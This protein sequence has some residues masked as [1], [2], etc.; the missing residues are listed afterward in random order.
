VELLVNPP[1][2]VFEDDH[3]LV[4]NKPPGLNTHAPSPFAGEGLFDWL[5]HR[6]ARWAAL[7]IIHRLDKET[8]GLI[9]FSKTAEANRSLTDQF[10]NRRVKKRYVF[11][12]DRAVADSTFTLK[13]SLVRV[14]DR[15]LSRPVSAAGPVAETRFRMLAK[16]ETHA[17]GQGT[18]LQAEPVTGRTHQIRVHAAEAGIPILGDVRYGGTPAPRVCL[19]AAELSLRHP[20]SKQELQFQAAADFQSNPSLSLRRALIE[21]QSTTAFRLVHGA[22][23]GCPQLYVDV[24][25]PYLLAQSSDALNRAQ[26]ATLT[27]LATD[28]STQSVYHKRLITASQTSEQ[29]QIS[30]KL[31]FGRPALK[32][33][34]V[35]ENGL[36]YELGFNE[37]Y[38][39][40]LFLDQRD[41]RRRLLSG[42]IAAGFHLFESEPLSP[43]PEVLNTFAYTCGFSVCAAKAGA[44]ATSLD[45]SKNYL[46][47]GKRNFVANQIDPADHDFVFGDVFDWMRRFGKRRRRFDVVLIDPPTFS[48]S[49]EFGPF[50][51]TRDYG[52]LVT[53]AL[54]V[55]KPGGVLFAS[56]NAATWA[57]EAFLDSVKCAIGAANRSIMKEHYFPQPPDFPVTR[58]EPVYLKTVWFRVR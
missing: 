1:C 37:G 55:L 11:L 34:N 43:R 52:E 8:S 3:L 12:T 16:P 7:A 29:T 4:V 22:S 49:K 39:V 20:V 18:L 54:A 36:S 21:P 41:N 40:G 23:D 24:L 14:G 35:L 48:R 44:R 5:R 30:P 2:L 32:R 53:L 47:W 38:S 17:P 19:H 27:E 28:L 6:E 13:S 33:F 50:R 31:V 9:L 26:T 57:P 10:T 15:Y 42:H 56:S 45:L 58:A 46:E 51:V 25:G